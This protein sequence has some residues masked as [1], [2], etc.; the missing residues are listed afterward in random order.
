MRI[1]SIKPEFW[2]DLRLTKVSR[3]AR[4]LYI[5]LWNHADEF[6]RIHGDLRW[7]KG[8]CFPYDDDLGI[9]EVGA[10]LSELSAIGRIQT[11]EVEDTPY[12]YLPKLAPH[13][14]LEPAKTPSRLPEPPA[15]KADSQ[16]V[17]D[18]S[19]KISNSVTE[20][21]RPGEQPVSPQVESDSEKIPDLS[22]NFPEQSG[23]IVVQQV[24]GSRLQVAGSRGDVPGKP[25]GKPA[26]THRATR[27]APDF[28]I[29]DSMRSWATQN[30]PGVDIDHQTTRFINHFQAVP[31]SKGRMV[32]WFACWRNWVSRDY[33]PNGS[34]A[35][36]STSDARVAQGDAALASLLARREKSE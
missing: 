34:A 7:V 29:T 20:A 24:A 16:I 9:R 12:I 22:E 35:R 26:A 25:A 13:Q 36:Q 14:R 28:K 1:R 21:S 15:V 32:D 18:L 11:Y 5:A 3:D 31:D 2:S 19:G 27:I 4:L 30:I 10:L 8:H 17:P 33:V 23:K 6:A